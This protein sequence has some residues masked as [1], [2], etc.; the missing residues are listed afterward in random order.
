MRLLNYFNITF[1]F[2]DGYEDTVDFE[3]DDEDDEEDDELM[4]FFLDPEPSSREALSPS[5]TVAREMGINAHKL[6][7]MKAS[8]FNDDEYDTKSSKLTSL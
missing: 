3:D 5:A 8:F 7:L 4:D 2:S 1:Y 6:Q